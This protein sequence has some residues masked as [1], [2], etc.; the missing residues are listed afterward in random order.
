MKINRWAVAGLAALAAITIACGGGGSGDKGTSGN[1]GGGGS[2]A[3]PPD[4][5][6]PAAG[7]SKAAAGSAAESSGTPQATFR[8]TGGSDRV[9]CAAIDS[10]LAV[11]AYRGQIVW[12]ATAVD[13]TTQGQWPLQ[14]NILR[15]VSFS[16]ATGVMPDGKTATV[17]ISGSVSGLTEFAVVVSAPNHSGTG[18]V[19]VVFHCV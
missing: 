19:T 2:T 7:N 15:D 10:A 1:N 9:N 17:H 13:Q 8:G 11:S 6:S 14:G 18:W 12:T 5:A 16:P 3:A 4:A